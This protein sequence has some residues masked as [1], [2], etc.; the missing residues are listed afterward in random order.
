MSVSISN[1]GGNSLTLRKLF[2]KEGEAMVII[3]NNIFDI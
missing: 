1:Q 3:I 2:F